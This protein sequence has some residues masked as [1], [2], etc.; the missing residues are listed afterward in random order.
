[1]RALLSGTT[2]SVPRV[3]HWYSVCDQCL[4]LWH[5]VLSTIPPGYAAF[6]LP[7]CWWQ[8]LQGSRLESLY[9]PVLLGF[10]PGILSV[11]NDCSRGMWCCRPFFLATPPFSFP[12]MCRWQPL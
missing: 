8:P 11:I 12:S 9:L 5:V 1:M 10:V 6:W 4:L 2:P 3:C 7:M